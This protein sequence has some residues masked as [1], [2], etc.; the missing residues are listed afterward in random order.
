[1]EPG[2]RLFGEAT[3]VRTS[4]ITDALEMARLHGHVAPRAIFHSDRGA[5]KPAVNLQNTVVALVSPQAWAPL[6][7]VRITLQ[8]SLS[9]PG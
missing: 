7:C 1:M 8:R 2:T 4:L 9:L 5:Q 6:E 3:Y